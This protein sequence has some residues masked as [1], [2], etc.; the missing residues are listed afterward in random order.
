[1]TK[2]KTILAISLAAVMAV[3]MMALPTALASGHGFSVEKVVAEK[4]KKTY[5]VIFALD[6]APIGTFWGVAFPVKDGFFA[7][8][9]HEPVVDSAG[10][11]GLHTHFVT[12]TTDVFECPT[13]VLVTSASFE[14]IGTAELVGNAIIVEDVPHKQVKK[15]QT[16]EAF[17]FA[18]GF[19]TSGTGVCVNP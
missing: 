9:D 10:Q 7:V 2:T 17:S 4:N 18:I 16:D 12:V 13:G 6:T 11:P 8:T 1:M 14:E 15:L 19:N 3:S 5:D